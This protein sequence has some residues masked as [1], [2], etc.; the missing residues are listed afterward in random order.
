MTDVSVLAARE[1][2]LGGPRAMEVRRT[3]PHRERT[4]VGA[5]CFADHYGP[6]R[7]G[8]GNAGGMDVPPHPHTGLATVS[9]L[10]E[11]EIEHRDSA[12]VVAP[13]RPG[14]VN[15]M[16][17]GHGIAHSEVSTPATPVLHGVQL[18]VVLPRA[19]RSGSRDFQ[20]HA[21]VVADLPGGAGTARVFVGALA[22]VDAS[23]VRTA[24]P[25]LGAQ[26]DLEPGATVTL[27]VDPTFEHGV[28]LD[29]GEL[30]LEGAPVPYAAL[31][32]VDAGPTTLRLVAGADGARAVLLGG[33]PFEEEFVMW[34]NFIGSDHDDVSAARDEWEAAGERFGQVPD[35]VGEV[36]RLPAPPLPPVRLRP[37]GRRGRSV[38]EAPAAS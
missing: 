11:G 15:L 13:V 30:Q 12:G 32:I 5:W 8:E 26:L 1:V 24:T 34:W 18:W 35:Y 4:T 29:R 27:R 7:V 22:G 33:E 2:P 3:L 31:G 6:Q 9:W 19:G 16:S 25:L 37:R 28:L 10:F 17:A 38:T 20:H 21:P 36:P 14:E 23:P